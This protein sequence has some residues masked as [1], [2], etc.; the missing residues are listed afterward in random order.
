MIGRNLRKAVFSWRMLAVIVVSSLL[1]YIELVEGKGIGR[2]DYSQTANVAMLV[3]VFALAHYTSM[4]GLFPGIPYGFSFLEERNSGFIR[5]VLQRETPGRY[6]RQKIFCT[7]AAGA[8]A[9]VVP[10]FLLLLPILFVTAPATADNLCSSVVMDLTWGQI[11]TVGGGGLMLFLKGLLLALFGILWGEVTLLV[12][13]FVRNRYMAFVMPFVI[14]ELLWLLFP[15]STLNPVFM[16]R[17]DFDRSESL[18]LPFVLF[19]IYIA[20]IIMIV[21]AVF[22]RKIKNEEF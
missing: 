18:V 12:T 10:Y 13:M 15:I 8:V 1:L 22:K 17:S 3:E 14:F 16:I 4:A 11:A 5:L 21:C 7:G 6:I 19:L 2:V 9:T 20:V